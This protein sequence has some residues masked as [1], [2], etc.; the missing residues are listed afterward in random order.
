MSRMQDFMASGSDMNLVP[1]IDRGEET[2]ADDFDP[3]RLAEFKED[4]LDRRI[5]LA[6]GIEFRAGDGIEGRE[7]GPQRI[8]AAALGFHD[9][10]AEIGEAGILHG[11]E[12]GS[13]W[14]QRSLELRPLVL[15]RIVPIGTCPEGRQNSGVRL[16][17]AREEIVDRLIARRR[18]AQVEERRQ[19]DLRVLCLPLDR[20]ERGHCI[21]RHLRRE[22]SDGVRVIAEIEWV[23]AQRTEKGQSVKPFRPAHDP[24]CPND[25]LR[26]H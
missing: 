22:L 2:L 25:A 7:V 3:V 17:R 23:A 5:E 11:R 4:D 24:S 13:H 19:E 21:G 1:P 6:S 10:I 16:G 9:P 15:V 12:D 8:H 26:R 20:L 18:K 14:R